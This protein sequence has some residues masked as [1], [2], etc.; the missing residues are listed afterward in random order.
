[1]LRGESIWRGTMDCLI[2]TSPTTMTVLEFKTGRPRP[3]HE[4][5]LELYKEAASRLFPGMTIE[6]HLVYP[7]ELAAVSGLRKKSP[8]SALQTLQNDEK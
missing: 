6:T 3:E 5:Q 1:M 8:V 7:F 4:V 2:Q